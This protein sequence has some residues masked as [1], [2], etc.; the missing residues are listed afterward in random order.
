MHWSR[1]YRDAPAAPLKSRRARVKVIHDAVRLVLLLGTGLS[2]AGNRGS[3]AGTDRKC[4]TF[5]ERGRRYNKPQSNTGPF[6]PLSATLQLIKRQRQSIPPR[7]FD[8]P[9]YKSKFSKNGR[10]LPLSISVSLLFLGLGDAIFLGVPGA[11][12]G[13][14][15]STR[16]HAKPWSQ[17]RGFCRYRSGHRADLSPCPLVTQTSVT[18]ELAA[19][20]NQDNVVDPRLVSSDSCRPCL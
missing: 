19:S 14:P 8:V 10:V 3:L 20:P 4:R 13:L 12:F 15:L 18:G 2:K 5:L 17:G 9:S 1:L 6:R 7:R 11:L 16:R